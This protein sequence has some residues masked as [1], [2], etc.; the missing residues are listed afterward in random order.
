MTFD[1]FSREIEEIKKKRA[2][3]IKII[4]SSETLDA[5]HSLSWYV[6]PSFIGQV[7]DANYIH[8]DGRAYYSLLDT[9]R[10]RE[11]LKNNMGELSNRARLKL[12][13][14]QIEQIHIIDS[15]CS[16]HIGIKNED[17]KYLLQ[18]GAH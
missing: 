18:G 15:C 13:R 14:H 2:H 8:K 5:T 4:P 3:K 1:E 7:F 9:A 6:K 12:D 16:L 11:I 17:F 10:N